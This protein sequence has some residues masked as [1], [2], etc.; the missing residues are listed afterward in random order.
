M[1][2]L[3]EVVEP[4]RRA[5]SRV[6]RRLLLHRRGVAAL[7]V[8]VAAWLGLNTVRPPEPTTLTVLVAARDLPAGTRLTGDD[9]VQV[10]RPVEDL[11]DGQVSDAFGEVLAGPMRRG[12]PLTDARIVGPGLTPG[13]PSSVALTVRIGEA[14]SLDLVQVGDAVD[15][16]AIPAAGAGAL[17]TEGG[18]TERSRVLVAGARVL[19]LPAPA[20]EVPANSPAGRVV[21]LQVERS[22]TV[23]ISEAAAR[24]WLTVALAQ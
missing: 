5:A 6:R 18:G 17:A 10:E 19:A 20:E 13:S 12:E 8:G 14:N 9:V 16:I 3:D 22:A 2:A 21:V 7:L 11:P 15:V 1:G 4:L 24:E 23:E